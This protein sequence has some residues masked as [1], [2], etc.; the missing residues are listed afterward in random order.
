MHSS[1]RHI[2]AIALAFGNGYAGPLHCANADVQTVLRVDDV[3]PVVC[4][5]ATAAISFEAGTS[6]KASIDTVIKVSRGEAA[7]ILRVASGREYIGLRCEAD[8]NGRPHIVAQAFCSGSGCHDL[9]NF[10]VIAAE[11]LEVLL[12]PRS[13][14]DSKRANAAAILGHD[15]AAMDTV[16]SIYIGKDGRERTR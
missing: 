11:T 10:Y 7:T 12:V 5:P 15:V 4:G 14:D 1:I 6:Q 13:R 9:D 8:S 2:A 3:P 16:Y